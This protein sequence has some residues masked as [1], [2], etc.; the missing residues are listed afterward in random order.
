MAGLSATASA[1]AQ[2]LRAILEQPKVLGT[3]SD[4]E[5]QRVQ[6]A[7]QTLAPQ[8]AAPVTPPAAPAAATSTAATKKEKRQG[9]ASKTF[10]GF[11]ERGDPTPLLE[12]MPDVGVDEVPKAFG[13]P[14]GT[15]FCHAV[16]DLVWVKMQGYPNWPAE[17]ISKDDE[18]LKD[19]V[20]STGR[21]KKNPVPVRLYCKPDAL[22]HGIVWTNGRNMTYFD[23]LNTE[24]ELGRC[25]EYRLMANK[26][27][28]SGYKAAYEKAVR[29]ANTHSRSTLTPE[30]MMSFKVT[31]LGTAYTHFRAHYQAPRQPSANEKVKKET[32]VIVLRDGLE[33]LA[34]DL[35]KFD[36]VWVVFQFSYSG[37]TNRT[38]KHTEGGST[39]AEDEAEFFSGWK[40]MIVPPRDNVLR[41]LLA[42]RSPHRPNGIGLSCCK[43]LN[44]SGKVIT[45]RDH[46]LLHGTPILDIKPYL[47]FCDSHP[48]ANH[49]W[50]D[51]LDK[52]NDDHRWNG[53]EYAVHRRVIAKGDTTTHG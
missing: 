24:G 48:E 16:G 26:Y 2:E 10:Q 19:S 33:N 32:G 36:R 20:L 12:D 27:D 7:L 49:G 47:P 14:A 28:V 46:D 53:Q 8:A 38:K 23:R 51:E 15:E 34:R 30:A 1:A 4:A 3:L 6:A 37:E 22:A 45:I 11:Y 42:T 5:K 13:E 21:G 35:N 29:V 25:L 43:L 50:V 44:V 40:S 41:G 18:C 52:P 9:P 39:A 17:I 31:P